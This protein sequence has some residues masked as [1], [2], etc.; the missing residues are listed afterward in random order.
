MTRLKRRKRLDWNIRNMI[1]ILFLSILF[2]VNAR[3]FNPEEY[4]GLIRYTVGLIPAG[5]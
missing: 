1:L 5:L 4:S 2:D 3:Q